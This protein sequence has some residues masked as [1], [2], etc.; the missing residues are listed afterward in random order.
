MAKH[1][2]TVNVGP[3]EAGDSRTAVCPHCEI[4]VDSTFVSQEDGLLVA[5]CDV[6]GQLVGIASQ[7]Q[8][9]ELRIEFYEGEHGAI[10]DESALMC[11]VEGYC[12][13]YGRPLF[14][15]FEE[16]VRVLDLC[17]DKYAA[18][19]MVGTFL[20][21]RISRKWRETANTLLARLDVRIANGMAEARI[22][23]A[24]L[25][26]YETNRSLVVDE[27]HHVVTIVADI[28]RSLP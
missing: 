8:P 18:P 20:T 4:L 28:L 16:A 14:E 24:T 23:G 12:F 1:D 27:D 13:P 26:Q 11:V 3:Y 2:R 7:S 9:L 5:V 21:V 10:P 15:L 22:F 6:C 25:P 19:N 17:R